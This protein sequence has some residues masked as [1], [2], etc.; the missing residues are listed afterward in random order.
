MMP[1]NA[2]RE[3]VIAEVGRRFGCRRPH[4]LL[5]REGYLVNHKATAP[6]RP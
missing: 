1:A 6:W 3:R 5:K 4:M 2:K